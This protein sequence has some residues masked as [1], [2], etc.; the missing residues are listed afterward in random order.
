MISSIS[1]LKFLIDKIFPKAL[2][3]M[4]DMVWCWILGSMIW[5]YWVLHVFIIGK[6][7]YTIIFLSRIYHHPWKVIYKLFI[8]ILCSQIIKLLPQIRHILERIEQ[9]FNIKEK[10]DILDFVNGKLFTN[11]N[12]L[13]INYK[14]KPKTERKISAIHVYDQWFQSRIY[15]NW[16][17]NK[18]EIHWK[19]SKHFRHH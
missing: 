4:L 9:E 6:L 17:V 19:M 11:E 16:N 2:S 7:S 8:Q 13:I 12:I 1:K 5:Y 14:N 18:K 10:K 15:K 3:V